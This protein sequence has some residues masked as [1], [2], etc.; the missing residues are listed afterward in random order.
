MRRISFLVVFVVLAAACGGE[1]GPKST[2][3]DTSNNATSPNGAANNGTTTNNS[4]N[5]NNAT[6]GNNGTTGNNATTGNNGTTGNNATTSNNAST[7]N[8]Q[9]GNLVEVV[10]AQ[11]HQGRITVSCDGGQTWPFDTSY[12]SIGECGNGVDCD[13][14][15]GPGRGVAFGG[16]QFMT[17]FGWG[18]RDGV[19]RSA[20]GMEWE[21]VIDDTTFSGI[22]YGNGVWAALGGRVQVSTD[23]GESWTEVNPEH[24]GH[25]RRAGFVDVGP[26]FFVLA[27]DGNISL[28]TD[29]ITWTKAEVPGGC[30]SR[31]QTQGGIVGANGAILVVSGESSVCTSTDDGATF[32]NVNLDGDVESHAVERNGTFYVWGRNN[33]GDRVMWSST[34]GAN[35]TSAVTSGEHIGPVVATESGFAALKGG[36][37]QWYENQEFYYSA[38]GV[39]WTTVPEGSFTGS[40]PIR[41]M[42]TG[43]VDENLAC[44]P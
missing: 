25:V 33:D 27:N 43:Y 34:D 37:R 28:S 35:W 19:Y 1:E 44:A 14:N 42:T 15:N 41:A 30:G 13:H 7:G 3:P 12:E 23:G 8:N 17:T 2:D 24:D 11:G 32:T 6:T 22:A 31:I 10:V 40:H 29:G 36:W 38:D 16:G 18:E 4:A 20:N 26:G 9:A 5:I 39:T 21:K